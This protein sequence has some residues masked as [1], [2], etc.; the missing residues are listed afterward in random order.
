[1]Q[2]CKRP[3]LTRNADI[4]HTQRSELPRC[5]SLG[6]HRV[7]CCHF[8]RQYVQYI[9]QPESSKVSVFAS[10]LKQ[11]PLDAHDC[12]DLRRTYVGQCP[13]VTGLPHAHE[14]MK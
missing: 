1:M 6:V 11:I 13:L 4:K 10:P 9:P 2:E 14:R 7:V 12:L 3:Q 5:C 8:H